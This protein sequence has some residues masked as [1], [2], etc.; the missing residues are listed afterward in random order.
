[1]TAPALFAT[2]KPPSGTQ[3]AVEIDRIAG[4]HLHPL[5]RKHARWRFAAL[6][7]LPVPLEMV[8]QFAYELSQFV[9]VYQKSVDLLPHLFDLHLLAADLHLLNDYHQK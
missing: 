1:M 3:G 7:S 8:S 2:S 6:T 4:W 9:S 5:D